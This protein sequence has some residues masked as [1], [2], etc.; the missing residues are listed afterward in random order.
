M[1]PTLAEARPALQPGIEFGSRAFFDACLTSC[2]EPLRPAVERIAA[3]YGSEDSDPNTIARMLLEETRKAMRSV[4]H[5]LRS[6]AV[7]TPKMVN[8]NL[9]AVSYTGLDAQGG[10]HVYLSDDIVRTVPV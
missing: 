2:P 8:I 3:R 5:E 9:A 10:L 1:T 6:G 4:I 7:V